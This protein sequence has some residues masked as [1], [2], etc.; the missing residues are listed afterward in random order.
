[1]STGA[2]QIG[3]RSVL[4]TDLVGSTE[5][6]VQL[7]EEAAD[8]LRR[9]HDQLLAEAVHTHGGS[10]VK[11]LGDGIMATFESAA[12]AVAGA[13][14]IQQAVEVQRARLDAE[15][16]VRVGVSIGDI[17]AEA[18]DVF[19]VPVVEASRLC[20]AAAGGEILAA[21]VVRA[22]ARG[23]CTAVFE[24]MGELDLKGLSEP[25]PAC[26]VAWEPLV[27]R[28]GGSAG[29]VPIPAALLGSVTSYVGRP[30]LLERLEAEWAAVRAGACRTVLLSGEPGVGKTRTSAELARR[31]VADGGVVLY[32]R[33]DED[34]DVPYQTFVEALDHYVQHATSPVFGRLPGELVRLVPDLAEHVATLPA[35]VSSDPASEE[36]R[37]FEAAASWLI[38]AARSAGGLVLVLDDVHWAT[39]PTLHL[40]QHVVRVAT[41]EG[42]PLLMVV[43]YRDTDIDR[44][45]P[46]SAVLGDLRRL[47]GVDRFAVDNLS[48]DEV[49]QLIETAAGHELDAP[50]RSLAEAMYAETE[51]NPFFVGEVLRHLIETGGVRRDGDRWV[52]AEPDHI[53]VPEG[54]R[55]VVGRRLNRLSATAND[56]LSVASVIGRDF[57]VELLLAVT[58]AGENDALSALDSAT[59]ARL[60]EE[61]DV[62]TFRFAHALVRTTL[63][64]E[65]SATRRRRLH[66]HVADVLEKLHPDD[67]RALAYHCTE[68][69][70]DAGDIGRALRY[71][72]AAAEQS[73]AARAFADAEQGFRR[74][75]ELLDDG[76][77]DDAPERA[78]ALCGLG[79]A[80]RDQGNPAFRETLLDAGRQAIAAGAVPL[81]QRTV[82]AN[83]RGFASIIGGVDTERLALIERALE[84]TGTEPTPMRARVLALLAAELIFTRDRQRTLRATEEATDLA[85]AL[86]DPDLLSE[87]LMRTGYAYSNGAAPAETL[88]RALESV[89]LADG[90]GDPTR[91]VISRVY[92]AAAQLT[93]AEVDEA[94]RTSEDMLVIAESEAAPL[95]QWIAH[96]N[97]I[98]IPVLAGRLDEADAMNA[99]N[100]NRGLELGQDDSP[101]WWAS[102]ALGI[103][104]LRGHVAAL[105]DASEE[106]V[107][108]Y[109]DALVWRTA[110]AWVFTEAERFEEA[111]AVLD[112]TR[113]DWA[114]LVLEPWPYVSLVQLVLTA[115][116][117]D[118]PELAAL[119]REALL[120]H[121]GMWSHYYLF[122]MGPIAWSLGLATGVMGMLDEAVELLDEALDD[123]T[124]RGCPAHAARVA[125]DLV[126]F[127]QRRSAPGDAE[128][129]AALL[130]TAR[131][132]AEQ[133]GASGLIERID[134]ATA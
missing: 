39:K 19:G 122:V 97:Q 24:P 80:Q 14:A 64:E 112:A 71:T 133:V 27:K 18:G 104:W 65:L 117:L 113:L 57:D 48:R 70:P 36:Y 106:Y 43:T 86:D 83:S 25:L 2:R 105:A 75:L 61:T 17:A 52:V 60:V 82:L 40:M 31:A 125:L 88:A 46:L 55:D 51:G 101:E 66:R 84:L 54:V 115:Q 131:A 91:R 126:Q 62:D 118:D 53:T 12:E 130:V 6:R 121:R 102:T 74:A 23:R 96:A 9:T 67:V 110:Q 34:L 92:L 3:T 32:G 93:I 111:R 69:G 56:V 77:H 98:R 134:A 85:R 129:A 11:G 95:I 38:E 68:A 4:F 78:A 119:V 99:A 59:R 15:F 29:S 5:L 81:L 120:P 124:D 58:D 44:T 76:L 47:P 7:G 33:C 132:H 87:V 49:I 79:E 8:D 108:R 30:R 45:H 41:D 63:Y 128:R 89:R 20:A 37:L 16:A 10:V 35:P 21:D 22:L 109:P 13:I 50:I 107:Q 42:A 1:V 103:L 72:L 116:N 127:L 90:S 114:D 28:A 123:L 73:L 26:R 94:I 100:L